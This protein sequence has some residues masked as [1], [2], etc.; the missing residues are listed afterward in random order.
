MTEGDAAPEEQAIDE[1][2]LLLAEGLSEDA[3]SSDGLARAIRNLASISLADRD[4]VID[5]AG[6]ALRSAGL[7]EPLVNDVIEAAA[8]NFLNVQEERA[9]ASPTEQEEPDEVLRPAPR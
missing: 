6:A 2:C 4:E 5:A 8:P 9:P 7:D 1:V 3:I